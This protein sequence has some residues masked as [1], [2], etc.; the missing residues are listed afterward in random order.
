M[1]HVLSWF[2]QVNAISFRPQSALL[3]TG[4]EQ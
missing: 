3:R 4:I 2:A 1:F